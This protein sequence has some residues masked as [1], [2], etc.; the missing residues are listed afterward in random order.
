MAER[1]LIIAES[2]FADHPTV[3]TRLSNLAT[4]LQDL[5]DPA[6][7]K[8]LAERAL[9]IAESSYGRDH[10]TVALGLNNLP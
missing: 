2:Y 6:G 9:I 10:P 5:G 7:A 3:A 1:A 4:I 8:P